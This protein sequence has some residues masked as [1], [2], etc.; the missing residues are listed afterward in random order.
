[1][2]TSRNDL[3]PCGSGLKYKKCCLGAP[4]PK[5]VLRSKILLYGTLVLVLVTVATFFLAGR[6]VASAVGLGS[7][8]LVIGYVLAGGSHGEPGAAKKGVPARRR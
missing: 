6:G 2:S 3:C 1:M 7:F 5:A 8:G 4:D